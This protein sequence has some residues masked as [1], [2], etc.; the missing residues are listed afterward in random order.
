M[1]TSGDMKAR[2]SQAIQSNPAFLASAYPASWT[3]SSRD[4]DNPTSSV[5]CR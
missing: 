1:Q 4:G 2:D 3:S 5:L